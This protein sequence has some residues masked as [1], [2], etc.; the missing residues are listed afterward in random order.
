[1]YNITKILNQTS[2]SHPS[3][4]Y[5]PNSFAPWKVIGPL[6]PNVWPL[7]LD[8]VSRPFAGLQIHPR[9]YIYQKMCMHVKTFYVYPHVS[10][11]VCTHMSTH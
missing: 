2:F 7:P 8:S 4:T 5:S 9:L 6:I 1:M 3:T 11:C 10:V